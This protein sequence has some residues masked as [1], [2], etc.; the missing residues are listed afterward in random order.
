[1]LLTSEARY[2]TASTD[3]HACARCET[4]LKISKKDAFVRFF[5]I[6]APVFFVAFLCGS[7]IIT[8]F[9]LFSYYHA[10][11]DR[12]VPNVIGFVLIVLIFVVPSQI[13]LFRFE[14]VETL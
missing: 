1:M 14:K 11:R 3:A 9:D 5:A 7:L 8:Q 6:Q 12:L 2:L 13:A 4:L 10:G